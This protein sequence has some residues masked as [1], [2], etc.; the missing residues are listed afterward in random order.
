[1]AHLALMQHN[2]AQPVHDIEHIEIDY[3]YTAHH[4][5]CC[6]KRIHDGKFP[7]PHACL[8]GDGIKLFPHT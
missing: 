5:E 4:V 2:A 6:F 1:M 3:V 8:R 7:G